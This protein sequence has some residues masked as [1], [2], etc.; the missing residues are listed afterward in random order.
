MIGQGV[1]RCLVLAGLLAACTPAVEKPVAEPEAPKA[2][3]AVA[4]APVETSEAAYRGAAVAG[5]VCSQCH[6]VGMGTAP[7]QQIGAP[8]FRAIAER[9]GS[10][11][12]G[13][14]AWM[15]A[16]HPKMP[17]YMFPEGQVTDL[18]AYIMSLRQ[19]GG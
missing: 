10:T 13:L 14:A 7:A 18:A 19:G 4:A 1:V 6:D 8:A 11:P 12:E 3:A 15:A 16:N 9:A 17:N 2:S 5:Q